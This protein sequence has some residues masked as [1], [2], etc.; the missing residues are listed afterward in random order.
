MRSIFSYTYLDP[1]ILST[2]F[3][4]WDPARYDNLTLQ[5][6]YKNYGPGY[7][8]T[9]RALS[10]FDVQLTAA[11]YEPYSSPAKVFQTPSGTFG[12]IDWIDFS[13]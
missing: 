7:N 3:I 10:L 8:T 5:A 12:N 9:G 6:E 4:D 2:G 13:V 1:S 11:E